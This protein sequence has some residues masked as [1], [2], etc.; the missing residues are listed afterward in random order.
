VAI[1]FLQPFALLLLIPA[2]YPVVQWW[3]R[4]KQMNPAKRLLIAGLRT[5]LFLL[6]IL[7]L[8]GTQIRFPV[9][10]ETVVFVVDRSASMKNDQRALAFIQ[11]AVRQKRGIDQYGVVSVGQRAAVEQPISTG[12]E[13]TEFGVEVGP[14]ATNLAEGIRLASGMIPGTARGKIVLLSDGLVT[15]GDAESEAK[16]AKERGIVLQAVSLQHPAG[17]E[18]LLS[19]VQVPDRLYLGEEFHVKAVVEST[20]ATKAT[21]RLYEGNQEIGQEQI[22]VEKGKNEYLFPQTSRHEGFHRYRVEIAPLQDTIQINN[23]AHA[24]T[25]VQGTPRVLVIEGHP[26]AAKNLVSAL[27]AGNVRVDVKEPA[28]LAKDWDDYR[29][30]A[31]VILADMDATQIREVDMERL[32]TAV[33]DLGIGLVMSGGADSFGMGGWFKTPVEEALPVYMDLRGKEKIPSLGL[34]LVIDKSGSMSSGLGGAN[35]MELAKEAAIR[36]TEMLNEKDY[37]GVV[38]F[39]GSPWVVVQPQPVT[40]LAGIQNRIGQIYPDGG[41]DIYPA[42]LTAFDQIKSLQTQRKH[43]ILLTDGQS[44]RAD[45]YQGLLAQM[46]KENITVSTVAVGDDADTSLLEEIAGWGKG[47]F[48][49]VNDPGTIPQ[50]FSKET[51]L[52]SRAF[53][54]EKP[55]IPI[56]TGG[57]DWRALSGG[58]PPLHAYVATTLKQTSE[59]ILASHDQDPVLARWQYGLG[60]SVAWT[61]DLEGKWSPLWV[62]WGNYSRLWN[63]IVSWTFPQ[64]AAGDWKTETELD[65]LT[66]TVTVTLPEGKETPQQMEAVVVDEHLRRVTIPLKPIEIGK[67]RGEFTAPEPGTYLVQVLQKKEE[68]VTAGQS[69][70]LTIS[71]SPEYGLRQDG[72]KRLRDLVTAGG[73]TLITD[74]AEVFADQLPQKWERQPITEILLML[75]ALL[76]PLDIAVRR[77]Y[78][79]DRWREF[80]AAWL[81]RDKKPEAVPSAAASIFGKLSASKDRV[82]SK[83]AQDSKGEQAVFEKRSVTQDHPVTKPKTSGEQPKPPAAPD[84]DVEE[85]PIRRLLDA[86]K[87]GNQPGQ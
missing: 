50:I 4:Q 1:D 71:Y 12:T 3:R 75:A 30:Y 13:I 67:L 23:Q 2:L 18:V 57:D 17:D 42:L 86:K 35:K 10:A 20:I 11:E 60:R 32:R 8:A 16:L 77:L 37:V 59:Q 19:S 58:T 9:Q 48:Y 62:T 51:A 81:R 87:R 47:R 29:Q 76:W 66:A 28:L 64:L 72:E 83:P 44:G 69:A 65:G 24:F 5:M 61:S 80:M 31:S 79:P 63:E 25:Y 53:I 38:A 26:G 46:T 34:V 82:Y 84:A 27:Q 39:D 85:K 73:G 22:A 43:V 33:S 78:L 36:S 6:L 74:P 68:T 15:H 7:A 14:H 40:D 54:V 49:F 21:I 45:D 41:T 52:A 55:Q 70:G 56:Q